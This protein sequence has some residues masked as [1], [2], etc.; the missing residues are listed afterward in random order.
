MELHVDRRGHCGGQERQV[1]QGVE[2]RLLH[3]RHTTQRRDELLPACFAQARDAV[4]RTRSHP[5]A[6]QLAVEPVR[7]PVCLVADALQHEQR[8]AAAWHLDRLTA[9]RQVHLL[10]PLGE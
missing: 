3:R 10:E 8:L 5:L 4:E 2:R 9:P 7:E 1:L 6:A